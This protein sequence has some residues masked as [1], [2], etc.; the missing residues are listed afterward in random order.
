MYFI[1]NRGDFGKSDFSDRFITPPHFNK[2][3]EFLGQRSLVIEGGRGSGKTTLLGYLNYRTQFGGAIQSPINN[4]IT[5]CLRADSQF[6][7]TM[8]GLEYDTD[9]WL[10]IFDHYLCLYFLRELLEAIPLITK[11]LNLDSS[12]NTLS[13]LDFTP[14]TGFDSEIPTEFKS[15]K[16]QI[17]KRQNQ[18]YSWLQNG[19]EPSEKPKLLPCRYVLTEL[20]EVFRKQFNPLKKSRLLLFID[21]YENLLEYQQKFINTGIK[22]SGQ[23]GIIFNIAV[24]KEG[25]PFKDTINGGEKLQLTHDYKKISI[26]EDLLGTHFKIFAAELLLF[27]LYKNSD[28]PT[29]IIN[30]EKLSSI[31]RNSLKSRIN[32]DYARSLISKARS[33]LPGLNYE[34]LG[35]NA[36][37]TPTLHRQLDLWISKAL[38]ERQSSISSG[39]FISSEH[40]QAS[41]VCGAILSQKKGVTSPEQLIAELDKHKSG[42]S[43][44]F[45]SGKEWIHNLFLGCYIKLHRTPNTPIL[46]YAGFDTFVALSHQNT[47]NFIELCYWAFN[48]HDK[49]LPQ[50]GAKAFSIPPEIQAIAAKKAASELY[51]EV[52]GSG[53]YSNKLQTL[54]SALGQ[55]FKARQESPSQS[56]PQSS[57]F[58]LPKGTSLLSERVLDEAIKWSVLI[59]NDETKTKDARLESIEYRLNPIFSPHFRISY[60][61]GR[62]TEFSPEQID[63]I[64]SGEAEK[65]SEIIKGF[66]SGQDDNSNP[67]TIDLF[68]L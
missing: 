65:I 5:I 40:P 39:D 12:G 37:N 56:E 59:P 68:K 61:K 34:S 26:E 49:E 42:K 19:A 32:D 36:I 14:L 53:D 62:K 8:I 51:R 31:E 33:I 41:V 9:S 4:D 3:R 10:K 45:T 30:L 21:E 63:T 50:E 7:R 47:R 46:T 66:S 35:N 29:T 55:I 13:S 18:L 2:I 25:M 20:M 1:V 60:N 38:K 15:L 28:S 54:A 57:H 24:K 27:N 16:T 23:G 44:N 43:S 67:Q 6:L 11:K 58:S 22:H 64:C 48:F 52:S 17:I